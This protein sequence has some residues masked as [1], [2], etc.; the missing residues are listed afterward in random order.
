MRV[1]LTSAMGTRGLRRLQVR[2]H[3]TVGARKNCL[4]WDIAPFGMYKLARWIHRRFLN[5]EASGWGAV[6]AASQLVHIYLV[7]ASLPES[8]LSS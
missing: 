1:Q 8:P 7:A 3:G 6:D 5:R 4:N 2:W